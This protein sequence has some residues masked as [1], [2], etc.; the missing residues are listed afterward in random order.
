MPPGNNSLLQ[1]LA[2]LAQRGGGNIP[3]GP[4]MGAP[5]M[6]AG[7]PNMPPEVLAALQRILSQRRIPGRPPI[8][9]GNMPPTHGPGG[10]PMPGAG[11]MMPTHPGLANQ[12]QGPTP[13]L[14][15]RTGQAMPAP[16]GYMPMGP[17]AGV[18]THPG[19]IPMG[20]RAVPPPTG[21]AFGFRRY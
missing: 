15:P 11:P 18:P 10:V 19:A 17:R 21:P 12:W 13:W 20:P 3:Q 7:R 2:A 9:P 5:P 8:G 6:M 1:L 4:P 14:G 16:P